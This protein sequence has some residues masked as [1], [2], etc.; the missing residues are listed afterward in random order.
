MTILRGIGGQYR[1]ISIEA[2][3][4]SFRMINHVSVILCF[5]NLNNK[6]L[7]VNTLSF[8]DMKRIVDTLQF[9]PNKKMMK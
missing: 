7:I 2:A 1:G 9:V 4:F 8:L 6:I 5:F 3:Y